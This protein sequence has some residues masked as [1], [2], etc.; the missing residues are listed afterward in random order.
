MKRSINDIALQEQGPYPDKIQQ[1]C[2]NI[3]C[4]KFHSSDPLEPSRGTHNY[5]LD[6]HHP[7][8]PPGR[9]AEFKVL[10]EGDNLK[11]AHPEKNIPLYKNPKIPKKN[12]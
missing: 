7:A 8:K 2:K 10:T 4:G 5:L 6:L 9:P 12:P 11:S 3:Y 1:G